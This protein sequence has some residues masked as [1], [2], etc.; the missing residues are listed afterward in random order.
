[1]K[2]D[3][4]NKTSRTFRPSIFQCDHT[5]LAFTLILSVKTAHNPL[6]DWQILI[7][8][9]NLIHYTFAMMLLALGER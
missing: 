7:F 3:H 4:R 8:Y 9:N 5:G 6:V 2:R 1:M